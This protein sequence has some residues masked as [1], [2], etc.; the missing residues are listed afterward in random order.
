ML[1]VEDG[2]NGTTGPFPVVP[3]EPTFPVDQTTS[4]TQRVLRELA[5]RETL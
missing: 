3:W 5:S 4:P 2:C 1:R